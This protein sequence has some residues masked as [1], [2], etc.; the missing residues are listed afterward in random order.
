MSNL[1]GNC[2]AACSGR[3][4][5]IPLIM[6]VLV[7]D[8]SLALACGAFYDPCNLFHG[9]LDPSNLGKQGKKAGGD[10]VRTGKKAAGDIVNTGVKA[11]QDTGHT[12]EKAF[13]DTGKTLETAVHDTGK[14]GVSVYN[15]G[16]REVQGIGKSAKNAGKR[17]REGKIVDAVWHVV[18]DQ[19]KN[20]EENAAKAAQESNVLNAAAQIAANAYGGPG[21][22]AAYAAWLTY[23]QTHNVGLALRVGAITGAAAY[24]TAR[25]G[26]MKN[27]ST[28]AI[29]KK[30][31][32]AGAIGGVAVAAAGGN[33]QAIQE[34]FLKSGGAMLVQSVYEDQTT[35][36]LD[37][38][39]SKKGAC[40]LHGRGPLRLLRT[41]KR[42][43]RKGSRRTT[44]P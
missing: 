32:V 1:I 4:L 3:L 30:T 6:G 5:I 27:G 14:A 34:G 18:T 29:A 11:V 44:D 26:K 33:K 40:V 2:R 13:H 7:F 37:A 35:H 19:L 10:V 25:V 41:A 12:G 42:G 8:Q 28:A 20:T 23:H 43:I 15:F 9:G 22:A 16:V 39:A 17:L 24:G 21:G 31:I 36:K 38:R